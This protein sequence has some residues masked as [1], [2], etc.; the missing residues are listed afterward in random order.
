MSSL[1]VSLTY[2]RVVCCVETVIIVVGCAVVVF[3]VHH[4]KGTKYSVLI[5]N[6][7]S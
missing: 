7:A 4:V 2:L 1:L 6:L 3:V 5:P